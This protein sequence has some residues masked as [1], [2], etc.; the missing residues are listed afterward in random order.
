V[1][2]RLDFG[3][4]ITIPPQLTTLDQ[5]LGAAERPNGLAAALANGCQVIESSALLAIFS[6]T[7]RPARCRIRV[8]RSATSN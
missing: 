6:W 3:R 1:G 2:G 5:W 7:A 8:R 4:I